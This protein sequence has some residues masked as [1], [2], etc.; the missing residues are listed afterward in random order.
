MAAAPEIVAL[1]ERYL[2]TESQVEL[3]ARAL[4][5]AV[6]LGFVDAFTHTTED[7]DRYRLEHRT[8]NSPLLHYLETMV[9]T[10]IAAVPGDD[11]F[12]WKYDRPRGVWTPVSENDIGKAMVL[13]LDTIPMVPLYDETGKAI[14]RNIEVKDA[15]GNVVATPHG[16]VCRARHK[17]TAGVKSGAMILI[18]PLILCPDFFK[19]NPR[20]VSINGA[21]V[22][23]DEVTR[24]IRVCDP[25]HGDGASLRCVHYI[26]APSLAITQ[27][28][29][30]ASPEYRQHL[31]RQD[32][33]RLLEVE[34]HMYA[35]PDECPSTPLGVPWLQSYWPPSSY[36]PVY[37]DTL[38]EGY[39]D[40]A[41]AVDYLHELIGATLLGLT[42]SL[43]KKG[44]II[45]GPPGGGKSMFMS[46]LGF[47]PE[48]DILFPRPFIAAGAALARPM[49]DYQIAAFKGKRIAIQDE[50][51]VWESGPALSDWITGGG[52][53]ARNLTGSGVSSDER[54]HFSFTP[55][56]TY[57]V[58][59]TDPPKIGIPSPGL[60]RRFEVITTAKSFA[61]HDAAKA[62]PEDVIIRRLR[63]ERGQILIAALG[64]LQRVIRLGK[65]THIPTTDVFL[66]KWLEGDDTTS[67]W[68]RENLQVTKDPKRGVYMRVAF[69]RYKIQMEADNVPIKK[70][71]E[72][73]H[74]GRRVR[75]IFDDNL[76]RGEI[77]PFNRGG[78]GYT[79][80]ELKSLDEG[81]IIDLHTRKRY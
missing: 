17:I 42:P 41:E 80:L 29:A 33:I 4:L 8:D 66:H 27:A 31:L 39:A 21:I 11:S 16:R 77:K 51:A 35:N 81:E 23:F 6:R 75:E 60:Q 50:P 37:L 22:W 26:H 32:T 72:N 24:S 1:G 78:H 53:T 25:Y 47:R 44:L 59:C 12:A 54:K 13:K 28:A 15:A 19:S 70:R 52:Q 34:L 55:E 10:W 57:I 3:G 46:V 74:F 9:G 73:K 36:W 69:E 5:E 67:E 56:M 49:Q 79:G 58:G 38:L 43:I 40:Q 68:I 62:V 71:V 48:H 61:T 30:D 76:R 2:D 14:L 64:Y 20:S 45:W 7:G 65:P 63:S 18:R